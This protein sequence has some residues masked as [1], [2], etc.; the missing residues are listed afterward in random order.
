MV[1]LNIFGR[2]ACRVAQNGLTAK[3][4]PAGC[5][6]DALPGVLA[7]KTKTGIGPVKV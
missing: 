5:R 3:A 1:D 2:A 4:D 6:K 7:R